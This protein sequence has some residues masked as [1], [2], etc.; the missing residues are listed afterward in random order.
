MRGSLIG[1]MRGHRGLWMLVALVG[2]LGAAGVL[3]GGAPAQGTCAVQLRVNVF[4]NTA[5]PPNWARQGALNVGKGATLRAIERGC[6]GLDHIDGQWVS[7]RSGPTSAHPCSGTACDWGVLSTLMSAADF[8]A[9]A[10]TSTGATVP[11]N[12]VRVAWGGGSVIPGS[13]AW[14][15]STSKGPLARHGCVTFTA[16]PNKMSWDRG[17]SGEWERSGDVVTLNWTAKTRDTMTLAR[18]GRTMT[19]TNNLGDAVRGVK[20]GC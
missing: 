17:G 3:A 18:D 10:R 15:F 5:H 13:W 1:T 6:A 8:T 12:T 9:Y 16:S 7:G 20:G 19:G 4:R 11:S 14:S 2:A